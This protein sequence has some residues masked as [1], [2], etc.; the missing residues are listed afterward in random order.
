M[1]NKGKGQGR[2]AEY[3]EGSY[4]DK[5]GQ[6]GKQHRGDAMHAKSFHEHDMAH[7]SHKKANHDHGTPDGFHPK[8]GYQNGD[9]GES[10]HM[11]NNVCSE[12]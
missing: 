10:S 2:P 12:D 1:A 4:V 5:A 6:Q 11:G 3:T 8:E 9:P 7:A